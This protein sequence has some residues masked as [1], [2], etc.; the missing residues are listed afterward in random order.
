MNWT[1]QLAGAMDADG[2]GRRRRNGDGDE[3]GDGWTDE[4]YGEGGDEEM[5][6][7]SQQHHHCIGDC[8]LGIYEEIGEWK[9][10]DGEEEGRGEEEVFGKK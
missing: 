4:K 2:N 8:C 5:K 9:W 7:K 6:R 1:L 3:D 10:G